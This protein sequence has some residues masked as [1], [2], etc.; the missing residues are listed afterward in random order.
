MVAQDNVNGWNCVYLMGCGSN[1]T[2]SDSES[3]VTLCVEGTGYVVFL[4]LWYFCIVLSSVN[5]HP[6]DS[7]MGSL[8]AYTIPNCLK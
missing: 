8:Q 6:V 7:I 4:Y 2:V 1:N 3:S 5:F